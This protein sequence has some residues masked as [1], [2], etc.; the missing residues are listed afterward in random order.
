MKAPKCFLPVQ[1]G[2]LKQSGVYSSDA[3]GMLSGSTG[4]SIVYPRPE[5][6][7]AALL[8]PG[9]PSPTEPAGCWKGPKLPFSLLPAALPRKAAIQH[10]L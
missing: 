4:L 2:S 3:G 5:P 1:R 8:P 10:T 9:T 6:G 7:A